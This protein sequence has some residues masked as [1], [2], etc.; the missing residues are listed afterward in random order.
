MSFK[1]KIQFILPQ[2]LT[3]I[4]GR[5]RAK[6][7]NIEF[8]SNSFTYNLFRLWEM[9]FWRKLGSSNDKGDTIRA[10]AASDMT[11]LEDGTIIVTHHFFTKESLVVHI[12]G[13]VREFFK[14]WKIEYKFVE[15]PQLSFAGINQNMFGH[16]NFPPVFSLAIAFDS[17]GGYFD[18]SGSISSFTLSHTVTGSNPILVVFPDMDEGAGQTP[19]GVT[20]NSA[21]LTQAGTRQAQGNDAGYCYIKQGPS[22]GTN[23]VV[24][25]SSGNITSGSHQMRFPALS[26]SGTAQTGQ[27]DSVGQ[28]SFTSSTS[29]S[30]TTTVVAANCWLVGYTR[31]DTEV[32]AVG[33]GT[34]SRATASTGRGSDS[35]G[36]VATG[37][38]S[39]NWT[40]VSSV[41]GE[42]HVVSIAPPAVASS[43]RFFTMVE[44]A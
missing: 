12:E 29:H 35:N 17:A 37:S 5:A 36:T 23:N 16:Q 31:N 3:K 6:V 24:V 8:S 34:T 15:V 30:Q 1:E 2:L 13:M 11:K 42:G 7:E 14:K 19:T 18:N 20:Y 21:S 43:F 27:P 22:T 41:K 9:I 28:S 32:C 4:T 40:T 39:L 10:E 33:S 38:R 44:K 26:Y 25:T